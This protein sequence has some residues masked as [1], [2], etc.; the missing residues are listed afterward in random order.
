MQTYLVDYPKINVTTMSKEL[1]DGKVGKAKRLLE[2][3]KRRR[4][5]LGQRRSVSQHFFSW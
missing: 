5:L 4:E 3:D 1:E 2:E